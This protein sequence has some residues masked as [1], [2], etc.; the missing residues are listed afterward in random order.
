VP[1][2]SPTFSVTE[3]RSEPDAVALALPVAAADDEDEDD[4]EQPAAVIAAAAASVTAAK[5]L[6]LVIIV[7]LS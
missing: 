2:W 6:D 4:D 1:F 3:D 7:C 5:N